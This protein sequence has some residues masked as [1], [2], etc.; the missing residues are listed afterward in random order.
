MR[1]RES[2]EGGEFGTR[3]GY[4]PHHGV[5]YPGS[6]SVYAPYEGTV[7][8]AGSSKEAGMWKLRNKDTGEKQEWSVWKG[9]T[10]LV[11]DREVFD[12]IN[13]YLASDEWEDIESG[14]S[15]T[16]GTLIKIRHHIPGVSWSLTTYYEHL[17]SVGSLNVATRQMVSRGD[18]LGNTN[19]NGWS[20]G[21]HLHYGVQFTFMG[22][23][24]WLNPICPSP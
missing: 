13:G 7:T 15:H 9:N 20:T 8:Y 1:V 23:S 19:N 10:P 14:W 18:R 21:A 17:D 3:Q 12:R 6:F 16:E 4:G 24:T 22:R 11:S 5:D 2:G